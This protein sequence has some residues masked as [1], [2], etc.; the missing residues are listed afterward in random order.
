MDD[1]PGKSELL[2]CTE[3]VSLAQL[4]FK[5][6]TGKFNQDISGTLYNAVQMTDPKEL[7]ER[8]CSQLRLSFQITKVSQEIADNMDKCG[9]LAGRSPLSI[10][11]ACIYTASHLMGQAK[12]AKDISAVAG[13]SDGTI[14]NAYKLIYPKRELLINDEWLDKGK[15]GV[16][17]DIKR[18]PMA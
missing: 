11:A 4:I 12:S 3:Y 16:V 17:G 15:G 14:R 10:A 9:M 8:F 1:D 18:L 7:C 2:C 6:L 13:V 5:I